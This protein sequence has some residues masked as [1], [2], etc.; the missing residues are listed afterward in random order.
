MQKEPS[1]PCKG[2]ERKKL[3]NQHSNNKNCDKEKSY[4]SLES[5]RPNSDCKYEVETTYVQYKDQ[6]KKKI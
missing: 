3:D 5:K 1:I 6:E 4:I 2:K